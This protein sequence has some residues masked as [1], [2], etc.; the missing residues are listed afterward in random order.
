LQCSVSHLCGF[1]PPQDLSAL[2]QRGKAAAC[3]KAGDS[4]TYTNAYRESQPHMWD[5]ALW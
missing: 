2:M 1:Q 4:R 5:E 3:F